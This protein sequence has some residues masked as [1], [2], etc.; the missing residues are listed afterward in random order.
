MQHIAQ[1]I[2][3]TAA[4]SAIMPSALAKFMRRSSDLHCSQGITTAVL[5]RPLVPNYLAPRS[6]RWLFEYPL[7]ST[8][9][10]RMLRWS[11]DFTPVLRTSSVLY[12]AIFASNV[13][14]CCIAESCHLTQRRC[15]QVN[16]TVP[17]CASPDWVVKVH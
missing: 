13:T 8:G 2:A 14:F 9:S 7:S 12:C 3:S 17:E 5:A 6:A 4:T 15:V 10:Q 16:H 1:K 11:L